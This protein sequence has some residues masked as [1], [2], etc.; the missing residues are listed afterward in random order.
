MIYYYSGCGNSRWLA[1]EL[2]AGLGEELF[3]IPDL[4]RSMG[5][6]P[7]GE[8]RKTSDPMEIDVDA[9]PLGFVFPIYAWAAPVLVED[10]VSAVRWKGTPSY[11]WFACTCGDEMGMTRVTFAKILK[12][13]GLIL[14][15]AYCFQMPE[16]YLCMPGFHLDSEDGARAKIEA[17]K[18]KLPRILE[19][20]RAHGKVDELIVGSLPRLKSYLIRPAFVKNASDRQYR[21]LDACTG[22]GK[23][24]RVCPLRNVKLVDGRPQWQGGCTQCMACYQYCPVNAIQFGNFTRGKG[25][26]HF[27][28]K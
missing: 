1:N 11:V 19:N 25:Q 26:Y 27:P 17:A 6:L 12:K 23:C 22:C 7:G 2:A 5:M 15:A 20:I 18:A 24:V 4:L 8:G 28:D 14:D 16:T 3:F 21:V 10:F 13:S 9:R